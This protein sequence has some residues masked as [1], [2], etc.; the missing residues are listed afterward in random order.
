MIGRAKGESGRAG[1]ALLWLIGVPLPLVLI[2]IVLRGC[3]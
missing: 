1:W 2:L 3:F